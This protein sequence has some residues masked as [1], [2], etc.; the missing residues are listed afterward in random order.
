MAANFDATSNGTPIRRCAV[1]GKIVLEGMTD[2]CDFY[3]HEQ[4]FEEYMDR[5]YG[6]H[7]WMCVNDDGEDGYYI[8]RDDTLVG[9]FFGTGIFYTVFEDED[10][11]G[12]EFLAELEKDK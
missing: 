2:L 5:T 11:D 3:A 4:C 7:N 10:Y 1:C 8:V 12:P 6:K 9:G